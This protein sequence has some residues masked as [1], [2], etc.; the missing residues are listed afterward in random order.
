M[1]KPPGHC[2]IPGLALLFLGVLLALSPGHSRQAPEITM[3]ILDG[4]QISLSKL[5]G[6][7]VLVTFWA[8]T[9]VT[10]R[11]E[12][13]QLIELYQDLSP[14]GLEIIAVTMAYDPPSKVL[15]LSKNKSL[16]YP[17]ALDINGNIAEA[18]GDVNLT[19]TSFLIGP[20]GEVVHH[21]VGKMNMEQLRHKI[22]NLLPQ[23]RIS[24]VIPSMT[25]PPAAKT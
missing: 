24:H 17:V 21:K 2:W 13:P 18:F 12:I 16:P 3:P 10:C 5:L 8:T 23:K 22:M 4:R 1:P 11:K 25:N 15:A 9:C 7:P 6:Q 20:N 19:P 14:M